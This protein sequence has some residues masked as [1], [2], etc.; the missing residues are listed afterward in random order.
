MGL[1]AACVVTNNLD[2]GSG[3]LRNAVAN[4]PAGSTITFAANLSGQIITLVSGQI[5]LSNN[6]TIDGSSLTNQ[7]QINGNQTSCIFQVDGGVIAVLNSLTIT[8]GYGTPD[9]TQFG[10][11]GGISNE[12]ALTVSNCTLAGNQSVGIEASGGIFNSEGSVLANNCTFSDNQANYFVGGGAILNS[13][14]SVTVNNCTFTG[15]QAN[16]NAGGAGGILNDDVLTV[17]NCTFF[18]NQA[19]KSPLVYN[20]TAAGGIWNET[21]ATVSLVNSIVSGNTGDADFT[22]DGYAVEASNLIGVA[23]IS[24]APLGNYGGPTQTMPPLPG[25]PAIDAGDDSVTSFLVT[26]QRGYLRLSGPNVDIGAVEDQYAAANN[27]PVL[28]NS[29]WT[30]AAGGTFQ[31]MFTN[32]ANIDFTALTATNVALPLGDW[33]VLG[34]VTQ[35][36]PGVYQFTDSGEPRSPRRFYRIV[37]P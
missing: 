35:V 28:K 12:G 21:F 22:N 13:I 24:L 19:S 17:N 10:P 15:N 36:S 1:A 32:S 27:P 16:G 4:A 7:V 30:A 18:G 11:A 29:I 26:D 2:S 33:T 25:S 6:I 9:S 14:G 34:N 5:E 23:N 31:F 20:G 8:N 3:S 37:S